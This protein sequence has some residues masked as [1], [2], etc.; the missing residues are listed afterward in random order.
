M[1]SLH[2][3]KSPTFRPKILAAHKNVAPVARTGATSNYIGYLLTTARIEGVGVG[4]VGVHGEGRSVTAFISAIDVIQ[5]VFG[6]ESNAV[7]RTTGR[8][9]S[10]D[11]KVMLLFDFSEPESWLW[12]ERTKAI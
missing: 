7:Y 8:V 12:K 4:T 5:V 2:E 3:R 1:S 6:I 10:V 11:K 9:V